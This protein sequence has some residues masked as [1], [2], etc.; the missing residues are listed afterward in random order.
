M[1]AVKKS[2]SLGKYGIIAGTTGQSSG[3]K[4]WSNFYYIVQLFYKRTSLSVVCQAVI[5]NFA[6]FSMYFFLETALLTVL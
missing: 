6:V 3:S 1:G 2:S 5:F 4:G